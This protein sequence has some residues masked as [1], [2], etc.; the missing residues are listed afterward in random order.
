MQQ[1]PTRLELL[2]QINREANHIITAMTYIKALCSTRSKVEQESLFLLLNSVDE[3]LT[4]NN[5]ITLGKAGELTS[6]M[7]YVLNIYQEPTQQEPT[8]QEQPQEV[9]NLKDVTPEEL[10]QSLDVINQ[11][12][13]ML[14]GK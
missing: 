3:R 10:K 13:D 5:W 14:S 7:E 12:I 2:K 1:Q 9:K 11:I 4:K 6:F 8:Q